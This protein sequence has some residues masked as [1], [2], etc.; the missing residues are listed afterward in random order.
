M[1]F[2]STGGT[3]ALQTHAHPAVQPLMHRFLFTI[4]YS[5]LTE[6]QCPS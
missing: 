6:E 3:N 1:V 4:H 2:A 5:L